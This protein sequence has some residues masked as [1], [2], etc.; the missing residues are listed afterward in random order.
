MR[1]RRP[2]RLV[3]AAAL[4]AIAARAQTGPEP[5]AELRADPQLA[6]RLDWWSFRPLRQPPVPDGIASSPIDRFAAREL[7]ELGL[8]PAPKAA[9]T[10]LLRRL[11]FALRG[12]P[13]TPAEITAFERA[14][15]AAA[16]AALA[17]DW[18]A[19]PAFATTWAQHWLDWLRYAESHGSE[20][21]PTIPYA[22]QY[23]DYVVRALQQDVPYDQ[24]VREALAGDLLPEKR[25]DARGEVDES[26]IGPAHLRMVFHGYAPTDA[27]AERVRFTDDQIDVLGKAFLGLTISC[28]RCHDHKFDPITQ[29]DYTA[30]QGVL[31]ASVPA[32]VDAHVITAAEQDQRRAI[33]RLQQ[34]ARAAIARRWHAVADELPRRLAA[35]D[36]ALR[37][38]LAAAKTPADLLYPFDTPDGER[39]QRLAAWRRGTPAAAPPL[40]AWHLARATDLASWRRSGPGVQ[41][42]RRGGHFAMT[43]TPDARVRALLPAATSSQAIS[44]R[45]PAVLL[46]PR[47]SLTQTSVLWVHV[48]GDGGAMVRPVIQDYPRDGSVFPVARLD[49]GHWRWVQFDLSYWT[50]DVLR[51][52]LTTAADQPVLART[53]AVESWF[54]VREV[55]LLPHGAPPPT[56][57][58]FAKPI[59]TALGD[60]DPVQSAALVDALATA[61]RGAAQALAN[62]TLGDTDAELLEAARAAGLLPD[63]IDAAVVDELAKAQRELPPPRR[64]PGVLDFEPRDLALS[65]RGDPHQPGAIVERADL[66]LTGGTRVDKHGSGRLDLARTWTR[67]GHPLLARVAVNR[68]WQIL[69]GRGLTATPDN[70]GRLGAQPS[71]PDLL[72][73]LACDFAAHDWSLRHLIRTIVTSA[74]WQRDVPAAAVARSLAPEHAWFAGATVRRLPAEAVRDTLLALAGTLDQTL[75]GPGVERQQP[76]R[77]LFVQK[78][79]NAPDP[80]LAV[81]DA[82]V[83]ATCVAQ[84]NTTNVPSQALT[85]LNDPFVWNC[86]ERWAARLDT[87]PTAPAGPARVAAMF[88]EAFGRSPTST[89]SERALAFVAQADAA[90]AAAAAA[91]AQTQAALDDCRRATATAAAGLTQVL[92][93]VAPLEPAATMGPLQLDRGERRPTHPLARDLH[94]KTLIALLQLDDLQQR[95]GGAVSVQTRDGEIF[96]AIVFGEQ[97]PARWMAG[98]NGFAR[99][100]SFDGPAETDAH[101]RPVHLAI[102]WSPEGM[103]AC[104]RDG[105]P[106]GRPYRTS[107]PPRFGKDT[108]VVLLG[109][110][111]GDADRTFPADRLLHG[112]LFGAWVFDHA[113]D[114]QQIA[115]HAL[116]HAGVVSDSLRRQAPAPLAQRLAAAATEQQQLRA[117]LQ[118]APAGASSGWASLAHALCN[119]KEF[120]WLR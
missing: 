92:P 53:D 57:N 83:P 43:A 1:S 99:T 76:R 16:F 115:R 42:P 66:A 26:A 78:V 10:T 13:P 22:W 39:S 93:P 71:C 118:V 19:S 77:S 96:D 5:T 68:V 103:V 3:L 48:A 97:Q 94:G 64:V 91:R 4:G 63:R 104:F 44:P 24:L 56:A 49:G 73:W 84:R 36:A 45:D 117:R 98:S 41:Q 79:R 87:D 120:A 51:V 25:L 86:A 6:A 9:P 20:G 114:S 60:Q 119:H 30:L 55:L 12:L 102:T 17:E 67:T 31:F 27:L 82:P 35:P 105:E 89:E 52:E 47:I 113:L 14:P 69:F 40:V 70:L 33:G 112:T 81:F 58:G 21:D 100:A 75:G 28:A 74:T 85:M 62:A 107:A 15:S 7:A 101:H 11:S 95:G 80:F 65:V 23:R 72:D 54:A 37:D 32:I 2:H 110:R 88:R 109:A 46:S 90:I 29:R 8:P 61:L 34:D 38:A 18:L 108:A 116:E 59:L 106:Y 50:G 111:H